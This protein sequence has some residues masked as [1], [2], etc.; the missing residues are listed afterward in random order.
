MKKSKKKSILDICL[1]GS[2]MLFGA[3][4]LIMMVTPGIINDLAL[5][6]TKYSVYELLNYGDELRVGLLLAM[7]FAI[8]TIVTALLLLVLRLMNKKTKLDTLCA[9]I[10]GLLGVVGGI[11]FFLTKS[12]VGLADSSITTLGIGA[13]LSGVFAILAGLGLLGYA[14]LKFKK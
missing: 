9:L 2:A 12:L 11:L 14:I 3:L 1:L 6:E 5:V 13:I 10:A 4:T 7:I 8:I